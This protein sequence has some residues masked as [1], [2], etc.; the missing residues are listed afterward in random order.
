[1]RSGNVLSVGTTG[2]KSDRIGMRMIAAH[3]EP[4]VYREF[5]ILA[6]QQSATTATMVHKAL[7][8]LFLDAGSP[9]PQPIREHLEAN[10]MSLPFAAPTTPKPGRQHARL[11]KA[12]DRRL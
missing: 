9:I 7:A 10:G 11:N 1:M 8:L 4:S 2:K 6:A 12:H 5:K 3:F